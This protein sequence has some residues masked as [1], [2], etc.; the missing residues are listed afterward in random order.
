MITEDHRAA[1]PLSPA[2]LVDVILPPSPEPTMARVSAAIAA[3][4]F[5]T[6]PHLRCE[7]YG[8]HVVR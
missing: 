3:L 5:A 7:S 2:A 6:V 1:E 8:D 4:S